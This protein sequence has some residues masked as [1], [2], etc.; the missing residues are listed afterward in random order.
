MMLLYL[1]V[2]ITVVGDLKLDKLFGEEETIW[3]HHVSL[4]LYYKFA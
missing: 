4:P 3:H 1:L 2:I